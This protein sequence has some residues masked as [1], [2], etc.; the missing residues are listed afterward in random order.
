MNAC[1]ALSVVKATRFYTLGRWML[2]FVD[3]ISAA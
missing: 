1:T 3:S 2:Y